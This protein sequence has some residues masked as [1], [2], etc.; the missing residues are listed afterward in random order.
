MNRSR[1]IAGVV[2]VIGSGIAPMSSLAA[3]FTVS[4]EQ[5]VKEAQ[6]TIEAT[7]QYSVQQKEA[8]QETA[9]EE[10]AAMQQE[11]LGLRAKM[12]K[13][14]ESIRADLQESLNELEQKKEGVRA[15]LDELKNATDAKWNEVRGRMNSALDECKRSYRK[16]LALLP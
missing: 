11:I 15:K 3:D 13:A 9:Q 2:V 16:L 10:L 8:F 6:E 12:E 7:R 1:L 5:V 14:S 4:A